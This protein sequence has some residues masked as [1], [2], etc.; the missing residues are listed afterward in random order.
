ML[1]FLDNDISRT[2]QLKDLLCTG[3]NFKCLINSPTRVSCTSET[4][5]NSFFSSMQDIRDHNVINSISDHYA[6]EA[7]YIQR[8]LFS[9][10]ALSLKKSKKHLKCFTMKN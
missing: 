1:I 2:K 5:I 4:T 10:I 9:K 6:L 8:L 7:V 3:F